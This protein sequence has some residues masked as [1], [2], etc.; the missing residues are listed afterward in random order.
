VR[1]HA[2][3]F[4]VLLAVATAAL[5]QARSEGPTLTSPDVPLKLWN[6]DGEA[7]SLQAQALAEFT[8]ARDAI[9]ALTKQV[10][11]GGAKGIG[12]KAV[13]DAH[14]KVQQLLR[15]TRSLRQW[16][17]PSGVDFQFRADELLAE[18]QRVVKAV[19]PIH[20]D[21]INSGYQTL[22]KKSASFKKVLPQAGKL[23]AEQKFLDAERDLLRVYD[24]LEWMGVWYSGYALREVPFSEYEAALEACNQK[25]QETRLAARRAKV[26]EIQGKRRPKYAAV[27][28][29]ID[30]ATQSLASTGQVDLGGQKLSGP[31]ALA[32]FVGG[33]QQLRLAALSCAALDAIENTRDSK[34]A[35]AKAFA[36]L[37][38]F[39]TSALPALVRMVAA[40]ADRVL[41]AQAGSLYSEYVVSIAPLSSMY[42]EVAI[43]SEFSSPLNRMI[44]KSSQAA[45]DVAVYEAVT[46]DYLRWRE[47]AAQASVRSLT[48]NAPKFEELNLVHAEL[49]SPASEV[50]EG[51]LAKLLNSTVTLRNL[52]GA[53]SGD[54]TSTAISRY[55]L[56]RISISTRAAAAWA[57]FKRDLLVDDGT[58]PLS[59][60]AAFALESTRR[61]DLIAAVGKMVAFEVQPLI[62][63]Y[64]QLGMNEWGIAVQAS[65]ESEFGL[66]EPQRQIRLCVDVAPDWLQMRY[67]YI[68]CRGQN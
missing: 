17:E 39:Q 59:L 16:G 25:L 48:V 58:P 9:S 63:L 27:L 18:L 11:S 51:D 1:I 57:S 42:D 52:R 10:E 34:N 47:R 4:A 31:Q 45:A 33:L 55:S 49:G 30:E 44:G 20:I 40:D 32:R 68:D 60:E 8:A 54:F 46:S 21:A 22:L 65:H 62:P 67:G 37:A 12:L 14:V 26:A 28:Q 36:E 6:V 5:G 41:E 35:N 56:G 50:F 7:I 53:P 13:G 23:F 38:A 24:E 29:R 43:K 15:T 19:K 64:S 61:G 3:T 2:S 66:I